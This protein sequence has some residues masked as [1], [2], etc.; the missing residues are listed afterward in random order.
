MSDYIYKSAT[1]LA[2][3]IRNGEATST[4]VIHE[5]LAQIEKYNSAINAV[6]I[7]HKE[8]AIKEAALCD[9]EA[10][11]GSFRGPLHGV[12]M[13]VKEQFWLKDTKSTLNSKRLKDW[14]APEDALAI[15]R[16]K[17]AG[18]IILGKT[19]VAKELLDYQIDGDIYPIC[20]N[21]YDQSYS[22]GGSSGGASAALASGMVPVELGGD[23]G[24]SIRIPSNFCGLYGLKTTDNSIPG[25]GHAP[26]PKEAKGFLFQMAVSG[27]MARTPEDLELIWNIIKGPDKVDRSVPPIEWGHPENKKLSDYKIGWVDKWPGYDTS[28]QT[29]DVIREFVTQVSDRG[30]KTEQSPPLNDLHQR[31]LEVYKRLSFQM[32]FQDV[33]W[34]IKPF[35]I[36]SLKKRFLRGMKNVKWK[37]I[38]TFTD[39]SEMMGK[40]SQVIKDWETYFED[41]DFLVCPAGFGPAYQRCKIGTPIKYD[42]K[43]IIYIHYVWS[44][45]ACFNGSGHPAMSIPLGLGKE[46]LPVGI[47]LVGPYWSEPEM[48]HF[49]KLISDFIP[50]FVRPKDF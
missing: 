16:L 2:R 4:G 15:S 27:P 26:K 19:N 32:I 6:V 7:L 37:F 22:P 41:F 21:P 45:N 49:A 11:A 25:H 44:Y 46:G 13:T 9:E 43:S 36:R 47:Q 14:V 40:K 34:F 50:G 5:H 24:G 8:Q 33:P 29:Q 18:A 42:G 31:S 23:F 1:E 30:V 3:L 28:K 10:R 39:Y 35:L 12:P 17:Q 38:E 20:K 48:L